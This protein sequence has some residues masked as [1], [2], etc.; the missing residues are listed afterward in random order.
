MKSVFEF[1][2]LRIKLGVKLAQSRLTPKQFIFF[3]SILVGLSVGIAAVVLKAF[4]HFVYYLA[5]YE[6][7]S[8]SKYFYLF[9]PFLGILI[10]VVVVR[11]FFKSNFEKGLA[12]IHYGIAQKSSFIKSERMYDQVVTSSLTVG[13]GGSVGLEAPIVITGAAFGS[14]YAK[15]YHLN[16]N[17][18]TLLLACGIAAGIAAAFNAPIAGVLF[19]LEV[20]LLDIS[21]AAFTPLIIA[22]A[23][24][25]LV[26]KVLQSGEI[27]LSVKSTEDFDYMNVPF[28]MVLG[29][30]CGLLAVYHSRVF[31]KVEKLFHRT[32]GGLAKK[33]LLG[34]L[35][36]A[37]LIAL[38]PSLF[39]EGFQSIKGL[40]S[41][42]LSS[43][44]DQSILKEYLT[45]EWVVLLFVGVII[46]LKAIASGLTIGGGG[47]GGN[48]APSMFVGAYLGYFFSR[49]VEILKI[50]DLPVSNFT[51]VGMAGLLSGMYH[52]PLTSIFL[53][54]EITGGYSLMIPLMIV[55]SISY[56][57]SKYFEPFSMDQRVLAKTGEILTENRDA[58][59]LISMS[60][61]NLIFR[62]QPVFHPRASLGELVELISNS[63]HT[64]FP[65]VDHSGKLLGIV[66]LND[67]R[68]I[69][70][71]TDLYNKIFVS[72]LM[73]NV[74]R[75]VTPN[76]PM[77]EV[78]KVFDETNY[79][80][81][82]V[83]EDGK[84]YGLISKTE[85]FSAYRDHLKNARI[86]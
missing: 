38:F 26:S 76:T 29:V 67:I 11:K 22:A 13:T 55:S 69:M 74:K 63:E 27:L 8:N 20:L 33:A 16:Y 50:H 5:T 58:N 36:L 30:L 49:L 37:V 18:R 57:I 17:E 7:L 1:V 62:D 51:M 40:S 46:F 80:I 24:G 68:E 10:T 28:Y 81:L 77:S 4:V 19:A 79:W 34:G 73:N 21:I 56:A 35:A 75:T 3:S 53:I 6:K 43:L 42:N 45:G 70:F 41:N 32:E 14:N 15:E 72:D 85:L 23:C 12:Q 86:G 31:V 39:G 47:N 59:V 82:P 2:K 78:M 64:V 54:A 65:V 44:L 84:Y 48:F 9:L 25:A 71:K 66:F 60:T 83:I 61:K 52:A